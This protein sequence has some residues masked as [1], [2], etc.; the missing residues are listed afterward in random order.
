MSICKDQCGTNS[1]FLDY[2]SW[3]KSSSVL[4]WDFAYLWKYY[5][6]LCNDQNGTHNFKRINL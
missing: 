4:N 3:I 1:P 5:I 6:K 2:H